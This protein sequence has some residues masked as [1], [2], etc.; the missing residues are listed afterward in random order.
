MI[1]VLSSSAGQEQELQA[2]ARGAAKEIFAE[3]SPLADTAEFGARFGTADADLEKVRAWLES[4]G[5]TV[6]G[7][8]KR[9][10]SL[11]NPTS[12]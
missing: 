12:N 10:P 2:V 9:S 8:A 11:H 6:R 3:L 5:F 7:V 1:L 4:N